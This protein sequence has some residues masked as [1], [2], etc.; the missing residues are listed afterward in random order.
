VPPGTF[1]PLAEATGLVVPLGQWVLEEACRTAAG[2]LATGL[3]G[4]RPLTISVNVSG[5]QLQRPG[6]VQDVAEALRASGLPARLLVLEVTESMLLADIET[7]IGR[8]AA[9]RA[10]GVRVALDD[11]GT[12]YSSL[13]YLQRL[14]VDVLKIDRSFVADV[15]A[16]SRPAAVARAVLTLADT[17]GLQTVAEG[18][19][20]E[21]QHA[22]LVGMGCDLGQGWLYARPV[23]AGAFRQR[24]AGGTLGPVASAPL[25]SSLPSSPPSA[26]RAVASVTPLPTGAA[27]P[28]ASPTGATVLLVDDDAAIRRALRRALEHDGYRVLD[29]ADGAEALRLIG[30][31]PGAI[32]L[33]LTDVVM[34]EL[35]GPSLAAA[36]AECAPEARVVLMSGADAREQQAAA[37]AALAAVCGSLSLHKPF[38]M[39]ELRRVVAE[40]LAGGART[41]GPAAA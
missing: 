34:P 8:L 5:R 6:F 15:T 38:A 9:L 36:L 2:W 39:A 25:P 14:P 29:A 41:A 16:G 1:I 19:E 17:L 33:V 35:S 18:I 11:F 3:G 13:A 40:A 12:G 24:V 22:E 20:V 27:V 26:V 10:L 7:A 4:D 30:A 31:R 37:G 23:E 28:A 21:A 32:D